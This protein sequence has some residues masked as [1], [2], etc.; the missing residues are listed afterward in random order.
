MCLFHIEVLIKYV[1]LEIQVAD[2]S[3][4]LALADIFPLCVY[5]CIYPK[6]ITVEHNHK[7][8]H[9]GSEAILSQ[10]LMFSYIIL[11]I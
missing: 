11:L 1:K 6:L 10:I 2:A 9:M 3:F 8:V 5:V 7:E 4:F